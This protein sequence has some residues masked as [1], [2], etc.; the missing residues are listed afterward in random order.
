MK[1]LVIFDTSISGPALGRQHFAAGD[2]VCLFPM[3]F[4]GDV[5]K[6][7]SA[8][9]QKK[10]C[11]TTVVNTSELINRRA[12]E[13]KAKYLEF[14]AEL[15][16]K[17]CHDGK[18][19]K[20]LF[21]IDDT[22]TLW[23][24][25][26]IAEKS[27]FKSDAFNTIVQ[28]D[29]IIRT[30][31]DG[32]IGQV[33]FGCRSHILE[34]ELLKYAKKHHLNISVI[35]ER[36]AQ[37]KLRNILK[38]GIFLYFAHTVSLLMAV[39]DTFL[40]A[41]KI[42]R[43]FGNPERLSRDKEDIVLTTYFPAIDIEKAD[44]GIF[45]N[46]HYPYLQDALESKN[47]SV[48]WAMLYTQHSSISFDA[49]IRYAKEFIK[50][51]Y[52]IIFVNSFC[53]AGRLL[54]AFRLVLLSGLKFLY[55][56][57]RIKEAHAFEGYN[58]YGFLRHDWHAS[59]AGAVGY[60]GLLY[61][62]IFKEMVRKINGRVW[63][64][65]TEMHF[66][67]KALIDAR[68]SIGSGTSLFAYQPAGI[69][70]M[71]LFYF[72]DPREMRR[73]G[74][75]PMPIPDK[76][77]CDG[78]RPHS[79]MVQSGW[80]AGR[81]EM[82]EAIRY[83]HLRQYFSE[84]VKQDRNEILILLS[85]HPRESFSVLSAA[86]EAF[87]GASGI[88]IQVKPHPYLNLDEVSKL[89]RGRFKG[90]PFSIKEGSLKDALSEARIIIAGETTASIEALAYG[91]ELINVDS[92]YW[93]NMSPLRSVRSSVIRTVGSPAELKAA[94]FDILARK[95]DPEL[96]FREGRKILED[97]FCFDMGSDVPERFMGL[98]NAL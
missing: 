6:M 13:L 88:S 74:S 65:P 8:A 45:K 23:W 76:L 89:F 72:N 41:R 21:A 14:V 27:P 37:E 56:E 75:Y 47:R 63:V 64:F 29:S 81:L 95:Y 80:E 46:I 25:S 79:Y 91:C 31:R 5:L 10:G 43:E 32:G 26:L 33:I 49:A 30:I 42:K 70:K 22:A 18:N 93:I 40:N 87:K 54:R 12:D 53:S 73:E 3:V 83:Y 52:R 2:E 60:S 90:M 20:E 16:G 57:D 82:V 55:H 84:H 19:L 94:A 17:I 62:I 7:V 34:K 78:P 86:Y 92:P 15:P 36:S 48:L 28:F 59:F 85:I 98:L 50:N 77:L 4:D 44:K 1:T 39:L 97:F 68:N 61:Y 71:H 58:I 51:G 11:R 9:A 96:N 24:Y 38:S 69:S 35:T 66:W 67:E